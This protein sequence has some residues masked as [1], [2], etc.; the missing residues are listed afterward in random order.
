MTDQMDQTMTTLSKTAA[1]REA[2]K[3]VSHPIGQGTSWSLYGP[4]AYSD[5]TGPS[6]ERH[7]DNYWRAMALRRAWVTDIALTLMGYDADD[8]YDY[9]SVWGDH[10]TD[11]DEMLDDR[12]SIAKG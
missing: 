9:E 2:R 7:S 8:A 12:V 4:Y 1:L 10:I 11:M 6:T 5:L 3:C